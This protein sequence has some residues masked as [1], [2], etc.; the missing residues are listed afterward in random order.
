MRDASD[1]SLDA[2]LKL[3]SRPE[4]GDALQQ[5]LLAEFDARG[6]KPARA[7]SGFSWRGIFAPAGAFA[8]LCAA[9][10]FAGVASLGATASSALEDRY[11]SL[12]YAFEE[13][14]PAATGE[15]ALW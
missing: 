15:E 11:A 1:A 4:A 6:F 2:L 8:G 10:Y 12:E 7:R 3:A 9:G 5:R 14:L 13:A